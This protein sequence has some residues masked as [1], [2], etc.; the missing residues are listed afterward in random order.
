VGV[1]GSSPIAP[2]KYK[3]LQATRSQG[4]LVLG[5][6]ATGLRTAPGN[7]MI[8]ALPYEAN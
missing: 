8:C 7:P 4:L 3:P 1:F 5:V 6:Q 2:T